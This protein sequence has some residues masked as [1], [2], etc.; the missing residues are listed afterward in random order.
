MTALESTD[1]VIEKLNKRPNAEVV[2]LMD[3]TAKAVKLET[4]Q[5]VEKLPRKNALP[6]KTRPGRPLSATVEKSGR[7]AETVIG[8]FAGDLS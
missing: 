6:G 2:L 8:R 7:V 3:A 4:A 1:P 5:R